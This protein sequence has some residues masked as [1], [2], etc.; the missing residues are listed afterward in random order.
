MQVLQS[1]TV[2]ACKIYRLPP[3]HRDNSGMVCRVTFLCGA[4]PA[5]RTSKEMNLYE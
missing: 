5:F 3:D 4:N 1:N 2:L